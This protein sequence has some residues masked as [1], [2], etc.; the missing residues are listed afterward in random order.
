M[1][2]NHESHASNSRFG[3]WLSI[4][5]GLFVAAIVTLQPQ[6]LRASEWVVYAAAGA[7]FCAGVALVVG[8]TSRLKA[9]FCALSVAGLMAS[10]AWVIFAPGPRECAV[11]IPFFETVAP[12]ISCRVVFGLGVLVTAPLLVW[13]LLTALRKPRVSESDR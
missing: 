5:V 13:L 1:G 12:D 7:F 11:S 4:A 3:G 6:H 8:A 10:G 2:H 9:F